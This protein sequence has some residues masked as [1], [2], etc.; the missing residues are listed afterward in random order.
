MRPVEFRAPAATILPR[1]IA[2]IMDGNRRWARRRGLSLVDG[3]R[4]GLEALRGVMSA[5]HELSLETLTLFAFSSENWLRP[6]NEIRALMEIF[7][8][9]LRDEVQ[10]LDE[11]GVRVRFV[12]ERERFSRRLQAQMR[13]AEERTA[14]HDERHLAVAMNY[15]GRWDIAQAASR[16]ARLAVDGQLDPASVD[17]DTVA[18]YVSLSDLPPVDLCIRTAGERRLSNFLLWQ[19]AY[20]ELYFTDMLWPEFDADALHRAIETYGARDRRF[21]S[22]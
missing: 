15:G 16:I 20:A 1:H 9:Y 21:G 14:R 6:K 8:A 19:L 3:Y 18:R 17:I 2:I 22:S 10:A 11:R 12:G 13:D 5:C 4:A 7:S